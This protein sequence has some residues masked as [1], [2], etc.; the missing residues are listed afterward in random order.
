MFILT[1]QATFLFYTSSADGSYSSAS[2]QPHAVL[3]NVNTALEQ[4]Q[5]PPHEPLF[6]VAALPFL[7]CGHLF[8]I[9]LETLAVG[10]QAPEK[11][12]I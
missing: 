1:F 10:G 3:P 9:S 6:L 7:G 12:R 11:R 8:S 4:L 5:C 2:P